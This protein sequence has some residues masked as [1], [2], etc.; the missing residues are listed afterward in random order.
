MA[1]T[2]DDNSHSLDDVFQFLV[3]V[4][5]IRS[6][7]A[8]KQVMEHL[9]LDK[10]QINLHIRGG[11]RKTRPIRQATEE[12]LRELEALRA[13]KA[14]QAEIDQVTERLYEKAPP[15]GITEQ[16]DFQSWGP[17]FDPGIRDGRLIIEPTCSLE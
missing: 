8:K 15:E 14:P 3:R 1:G 5:D 12:E 4:R 13:R 17:I 16:V 7:D 11:A 6:A 10:L 2:A 9:Q